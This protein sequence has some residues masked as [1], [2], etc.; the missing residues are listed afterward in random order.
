MIPGIK[1]LIIDHGD[2]SRQ[3]IC[4]ELTE[5]RYSVTE[6]S[7]EEE[8]LEKGLFSF[9]VIVLDVNLPKNAKTFVKNG[10]G[11]RIGIE[12]RKKNTSTGI[13]FFSSD[14]NYIRE[15]EDLYRNGDGG[16]GYISKESGF[17]VASAIPVVT[18]G[19]WIC[20]LS[21]PMALDLDM[22]SLYLHGLTDT[23]RRIILDITKH[24]SGLKEDELLI[25]RKI[26]ESNQ[27]IA[28]S[29]HLAVNTIEAKFT[30]I[31]SKL[32]LENI[33]RRLRPILID[34]ALSIFDLR[35]EQG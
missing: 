1:V 8:A 25:L 28:K 18:V 31:Y 29:L 21:R 2:M 6:S 23:T 16:V 13:L 35:R 5:Q 10:L 27:V 32:G 19:N 34:R 20:A 26:G 12:T 7:C 3:R 22:K 30:L 15:A 4:S 9:D 33:D 11:M 14:E 24:L 17:K